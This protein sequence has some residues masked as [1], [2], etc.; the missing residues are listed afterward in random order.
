LFWASATSCFAA[1]ALAS[2]GSQQRAFLC[3]VNQHCVIYQ[4]CAC[5]TVLYVIVVYCAVCF[6]AIFNQTLVQTVWLFPARFH[7][8]SLRN[9]SVSTWEY[10]RRKQQSYRLLVFVDICLLFSRD[11]TDNATSSHWASYSRFMHAL[12]PVVTP[13]PFSGQMT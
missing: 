10:C 4:F 3:P 2:V 8:D 13:D 11:V 1:V 7:A 6:K 12:K 5:E 9:C